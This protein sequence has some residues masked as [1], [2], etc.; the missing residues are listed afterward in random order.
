MERDV[1]RPVFAY[2]EVVM[3]KPVWAVS[4]FLILLLA[5]STCF[6]A[7]RVV[8]MEQATNAG[9]GCAGILDPGVDSL[10]TY[11]GR[12]EVVCIRYNGWWPWEFDRL[13]NDNPAE[14][15]ARINY[16]SIAD[17]PT[18]VIDG[19][20]L[21][22]FCEARLLPETLEERLAVPSPLKMVA[23]ESLSVDSLHVAVRIVAEQ[24][25][26]ADSLALRVA[27]VEDSIYYDAPNGKKYHNCTFRTML[28]GTGGTAFSIAPG[29]TLDFTYS[30]AL[31]PG[32]DASMIS[33]IAFVQN[34]GDRSVLQA[35]SSKPPLETWAGYYGG[36][37]GDVVPSGYSVD[38][39]TTLVNLGAL[40][41]TFDLAFSSG[42]P[43]DWTAYYDIAGAD[44]IGDAVALDPDSSC[45]VRVGF[46]CGFDSGTGEA[47]VTVT[48]RRD[49]AVSRSLDFFALAGICALLVDDDGGDTLEDFYEAALDSAG[50]VYGVWDREIAR[51]DS[52]DLA[53]AEFVIWFTGGHA[54]TLDETDRAAL[55]PYLDS[56][57][58]LGI[59]GQDIGYSMCDPTSSFYSLEAKA[60]YESYLKAAYVEANSNLF[61]LEGRG[62]DIVSEGISLTIRGGDGADNQDFADVID[63]LPPAQVIFD[64]SDPAKHGGIRYENGDT[65]VVYLSFGFEA[66]DNM[67]D[68]ALLM[69]RMVDWLGPA[70][71]AGP[72]R[73]EIPVVACYPNPAVSF[74][75]IGLA[76]DGDWES[77]R[78]YNIQ[79]RLVKDA[80]PGGGEFR[81]DLTD[82]RG[83]TVSPGI[84][85]V[86][87]STRDISTRHKLLIIR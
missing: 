16:Y 56:G 73:P 68:R 57:G 48:S 85:F 47:L 5:A 74:A 83:Q 3:R 77:L 39:P 72:R 51:V 71:S 15:E 1:L 33:S 13:Y 58:R 27:V 30:V 62:G 12:E 87:V 22:R 64:Y 60:F 17:M 31:D 14:I 52:A 76:G 69:S 29:E 11:Y 10:F 8:L 53:M 19:E 63:A 46:D 26:G 70:G 23:A 25:P 81:W 37:R 84:Y 24:D 50:A 7:R 59:S 67:S 34:D 42:L 20:P 78:I 80:G 49:P 9:C 61:D 32:W 35:V 18:V 82:E 21:E 2:L 40:R 6:P 79:G 38:F 4:F 44:N 45:T 36:E 54:P 41:D 66:V 86:S 65:R 43:G 28:P 55:G 75:N